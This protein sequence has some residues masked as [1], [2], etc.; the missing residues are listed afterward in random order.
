MAVVTIP[1]QKKTFTSFEEAQQFLKSI[2]IDYE[3]W[4]AENPITS[5]ATQEE[6]LA[7]YSKEIEALKAQ[8]GYVTADVIDINP[9]TPNLDVMLNK[10]NKEHAHDEDE[11]RFC[12]EGSG[13]FHIHP[14]NGPVVSIEVGEG[15]LI[16]VPK[17]THHWFDLC[18]TRRIRCIRLFQEMSGWAPIYTESGV[19]SGY[20]PICM[21]PA[22][23]PPAADGFQPTRVV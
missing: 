22:F 7:A 15:D 12:I 4:R 19:D 2:G 21:G 14:E 17:G 18:A 3:I 11:V 1:D 13:V 10:F 20:M 16:R 9:D 5:D 8:G 6:I 23:I